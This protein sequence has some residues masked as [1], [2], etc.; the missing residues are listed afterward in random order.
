LEDTKFTI[1]PTFILQTQAKAIQYLTGTYIKY[2]TRSGTK[3][4]GARSQNS[5]GF[6]MYYRGNMGPSPSA[7]LIPKL[8]FETGD[9]AIGMAY[10]VNIS[11]YRRASKYKG[12]FEVSLRYNKLASSLFASRKEF[13]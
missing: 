2:R 6:G 7:D 4:T 11:G 3:Q 13:R 5:I 8:L 10:D 9:F 1:T 12:G